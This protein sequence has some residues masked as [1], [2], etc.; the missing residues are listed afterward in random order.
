MTMSIQLVYAID[1]A[2]LELAALSFVSVCLHSSPPA[3][4]RVLTPIGVDPSLLQQLAELM[5]VPFLHQQL[6]QHTPL[7]RLAAPLRPYFYCLEALHTTRSGPLLLLDADTLCVADLSPLS[8]LKLTAEHP[9]AACSHHRPMPDRQLA[10]QLLSPFH[11]INAGVLLA[12]PAHLA[13]QFNVSDAVRFFE[14]HSALCRFREQCVLNH[15]LSGRFQHLPARYNLLSWMR[16]RARRSPWQ[17]QAVNPMASVLPEE[18]N[19]AA[20]V[21]F[22]NGCLPHHLRWHQRDRF[23]RYWL[24]LRRSLQHWRQEGG[25]MPTQWPRFES[26]RSR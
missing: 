21:H 17:N 8:A 24:R 6:P 13:S 7:Q 23:D 4:L 11:Y 3:S 25:P 12:D 15:L 16:H 2:C 20:I 10:L 9:I 26:T 1:A 22:S 5:A 14:D 19:H 18:R